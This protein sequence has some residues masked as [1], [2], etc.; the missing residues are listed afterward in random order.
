MGQFGAPMPKWRQKLHCPNSGSKT[1][2]MTVSKMK[3]VG[4]NSV[5]VQCAMCKSFFEFMN[6]T[7]VYSIDV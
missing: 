3:L 2:K 6:F 5:L 7:L 1:S 4:N